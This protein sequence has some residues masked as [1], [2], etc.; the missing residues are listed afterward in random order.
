MRAS[1]INISR[2]TNTL[3]NYKSDQQK[4]QAA[5]SCLQ[6][7]ISSFKSS[8]VSE[9]KCCWAEWGRKSH[10]LLLPEGLILLARSVNAPHTNTNPPISFFIFSK[11]LW[12]IDIKH[13][14]LGWEAPSRSAPGCSVV[15]LRKKRKKERKRKRKIANCPSGREVTRWQTSCF[16]CV[17]KRCDRVCEGLHPAGSDFV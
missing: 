3:S 16:K 1:G 9:R 12:H 14:W 13:C 11:F 15:N 7:L 17:L 6:I 10:G 4:G 2:V 5:F 8:E